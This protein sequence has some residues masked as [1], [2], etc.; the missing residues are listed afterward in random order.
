SCCRF[1][2]SCSPRSLLN[3]CRTSQCSQSQSHENEQ[4]P[5]PGCECC[6][7]ERDDRCEQRGPQERAVHHGVTGGIVA[8]Q[9]GVGFTV[10]CFQ[11]VLVN[12]IRLRVR[13]QRAFDLF[14]GKHGSVIRNRNALCLQLALHHAPCHSA[15]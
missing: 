12:D 15:T 6:N 5:E 3:Y 4:E 10:R 11:C 1:S 13:C 8:I 2:C 7:T 9:F 14:T